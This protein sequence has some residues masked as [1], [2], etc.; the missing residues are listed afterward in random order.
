MNAQATE[1][2]MLESGLPRA[3]ERG[4]LLMHYQPKMDLRNGRIVGVEALMRW[5][6]PALG[7]VSPA[8]FIPI[9]EETGPD[10]QL[11][12]L[13]AARW[14]AATRARGRTRAAAVQ[15]SV[16]LSP[17]QLDPPLLAEEVAQMLAKARLDPRLLELEITESGVMRNP[18]HA[19]ALLQRDARH[20]RGP[21]DRRLRHRLLV[22][23]VPAHFPLSTVKIDRSFIND[24]PDDEDAAALT[25]GIITLAHGLRM[26]VVAEGVETLEQLGYLRATAATRSRA[27]G[28]ASR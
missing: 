5:R 11:W 25:A 12:A 4:E 6:H 1:R 8:Q 7:M 21:G 24:L 16:N 10:R 28:S 2:L 18:T 19:A 27:T 15:M 20:G 17:R 23:V 22:A 3:L 26:K 13:G 9:A 14:P